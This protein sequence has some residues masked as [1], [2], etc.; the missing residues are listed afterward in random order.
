M[1]PPRTAA[2]EQGRGSGRIFALLLLGCLVAAAWASAGLGSQQGRLTF[3]AAWPSRVL[4]AAGSLEHRV[5]VQ[6]RLPRVAAG[7]LAGMCL[8]VA[9]LLLQGVTRNPLADPYLLGVSGGAGLLVVLLHAVP[10]LVESQGWWLVPLC[11]F[12][13]A[14]AASLLVLLLA[15]GTGGRLTILGLILGG[16]VVNALCAALMTFLLARFDPFRLRVTTLWLAGGIGFAR[17]EQ[18]GL[19]TLLFVAGW[20]YLRSQAHRLNALALGST[21]AAS[22]GVEAGP[23]LFYSTLVGSLLTGLGVALGGLLGYVGL[24]VPHLVRLL[25]GGDFR[26]TL[27]VCALGGGLLVVV[28][29]AAA[30]LVFAPEEL[31]VGVLTAILGCPVLLVLLRGQLRR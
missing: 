24:I 29:D 17:P 1:Q 14:Q 21:G 31:P 3:D 2:C 23:L 9:G 7:V 16:V 30:R 5:L 6:L 4:E 28:A 22:L 15:R 11:A 13:G 25:L 27:G 19:V 20:L 26:G 10:S 8:A 12:V 18:L